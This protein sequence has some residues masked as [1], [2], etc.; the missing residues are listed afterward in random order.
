V[1]RRRRRRRTFNAGRVLVLNNQEEGGGGGRG[2]GGGG[3]GGGEGG[4]EEGE[5]EEEEKEEI[6]TSACFQSPPCLAHG[7]L[8]AWHVVHHL[9]GL[10]HRGSVRDD[11]LG[12][13]VGHIIPAALDHRLLGTLLVADGLIVGPGIKPSTLQEGLKW[14]VCCAVVHSSVQVSKL[15]N[16]LTD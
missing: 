7:E 9:A 8:E 5:E 6:R 2:G 16:I 4:G 14:C 15:K 12:A 3:G 13:F 1:R 11:A 10:K